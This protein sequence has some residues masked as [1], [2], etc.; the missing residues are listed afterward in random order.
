MSQKD[1]RSP[2]PHVR[3]AINQ[4]ANENEPEKKLQA[5]IDREGPKSATGQYAQLLLE[6]MPETIKN[7][8]PIEGRDVLPVLI[9]A[10]N[11]EH[12]LPQ[13]LLSLVD[14]AIEFRRI[15]PS[16]H[17][18]IVICNNASTDETT[19]TV[20]Q[21]YDDHKQQLLLHHISIE[22]VYEGKPG[23]IVGVRKGIKHIEKCFIDQ[24]THVV[25]S[26]AEVE[27]DRRAIS[28]LWE[29]AHPREGKPSLLIGS[30]I[31]PRNRKT[32]WGVLEEAVYYGYGWLP[33]R[34]QGVF[35]KFVSGMGYMAD[36]RVQCH[37]DN[38]PDEI[39][40][41]DV[42]IS[43]CVGAENITI[44]ADAIVRYDL[45]ED[46]DT[47]VKV[48][49]RHL[50]GILQ[51]ERWLSDMHG[52]EQGVAMTSSIVELC[53]LRIADGYFTPVNTRAHLDGSIFKKTLAI[54]RHINSIP[55]L[56]YP[57][58][59]GMV[60]IA[61]LSTVYI[62]LTYRAIRQ[63]YNVSWWAALIGLLKKDAGLPYIAFLIKR[64]A[65]K[66]QEAS[67]I[68]GNWNPA[69]HRKI[70]K[71]R[72]TKNRV[73]EILSNNLVWAYVICLP[74]IALIIEWACRH[75]LLSVSATLSAVAQ[76]MPDASAL[77][78]VKS[79]LIPAGTSVKS[80]LNPLSQILSFTGEHIPELSIVLCLVVY[81]SL[82][83]FYSLRSMKSAKN[84]GREWIDALK[85]ASKAFIDIVI[86]P[87]I[88]FEK[89]VLFSIII[90]LTAIRFIFKN[91]L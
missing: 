5:I 86:V 4:L 32:L 67:G 88:I 2:E 63:N 84:I 39:E 56:N 89:I 26:D 21:F 57:M 65:V 73:L 52:E 45:S 47:F 3:F 29:A 24:Y 72:P 42:I 76:K 87:F 10:R 43:L 19:R 74:V 33:P 55:I 49:G 38:I 66:A 61:L 36:K 69:L 78:A 6:V 7:N 77:S 90:P 79:N 23:K 18:A 53:A 17:V 83:L 13:T 68:N 8:R 25:S 40:L 64:E 85:T 9:A 70:K 46:W 75:I 54:I 30:N 82:L 37:W 81:V 50:K 48:R 34:N 60:G 62:Y 41:E 44:A 31:T 20:A 59:H 80:L 58:G 91:R 27:W 1:W 16:F 28:A 11:E 15:H 22:V 71:N 14:S 51:I 35:M 12:S